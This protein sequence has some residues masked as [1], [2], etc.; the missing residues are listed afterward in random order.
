[1]TTSHSCIEGLP[2]NCGAK[3]PYDPAWSSSQKTFVMYFEAIGFNP[4]QLP[5]HTEALRTEVRDFIAAERGAGRLDRPDHV[6][7][8]VD[9]AFSRRVGERGWIG[10]TWPREY[11]GH[12]RS[13]LDRY[14]VTEELLAAGA[15]VRAHWVTD[16]QTGPVLLRFGSEAQKRD[17]LPRIARGECFFAIGLSEPDTGSDLAALTTR[18]TRVPGG[19]RVT[20]S[21]MWTSNIHH[22]H[23]VVTLCRTSPLEE[24]RHKGMSQ[25]IIPVPSPGLTIRP[26]INLAGEHDFNE[27]HL[28][29]VFVPEANLLG[30]LDR[31]WWQAS[32]ELAYERSGPERWLSA[33]RL[34]AELNEALGPSPSRHASAAMGRLFAHLLA[35]RQMSVA[36]GGM[37]EAGADPNLQ[38]AI[39]KDR[40][41]CFEQELVQVAR[42]LIA[43]EGIDAHRGAGLVGRLLD[44]AQLWT[45]AFTI[46]GGAKE[47]MRGIIA[48]GLGMR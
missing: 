26:I 1:M 46:R 13:A 48:R 16:R 33:F 3:S 37:L 39:V 19:W 43:S 17:Y 15:P 40:G 25:L 30:D 18:A 32:A 34:L 21:K 11:G 23:Y 44:H 24:D 45:V 36:V 38:A 9:L 41:T 20:G 6:G 29:D 47:I 12:E 35:L 10:M 7:M 2:R 4:S 22:A 42:E 5:A 14:V 28:D 31:G 8:R 27:V